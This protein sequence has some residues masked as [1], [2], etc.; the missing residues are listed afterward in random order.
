MGKD[1]SA[2]FRFIMERADEAED[3]DQ[4]DQCKE[5]VCQRA[6]SDDSSALTQGLV[7]ER[8][9]VG[10]GWRRLALLRTEALLAVHLDEAAQ[11]YGADLPSRA[12]PIGA[13]EQLGAEADRKDLDGD[14]AP[15]G[16]QIVAQL[17]DE[18][19]DRQDNEER[20]NPVDYVSHEPLEGVAAA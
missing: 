15:A 12:R 11:R 2:R 8:A 10:A 19:E 4:K 18:D 16:N 9:L 3:T 13:A 17:V 7:A 20:Q 5:D 1:A 14:A 6:G